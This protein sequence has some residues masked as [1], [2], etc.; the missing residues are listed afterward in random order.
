MPRG[1]RVR[2]A[3]WPP[4]RRVR[5]RARPP[6]FDPPRRRSYNAKMLRAVPRFLAASLLVHGFSLGA[7]VAAAEPVP[8]LVPEFIVEPQVE[9]REAGAMSAVWLRESI[10]RTAPRLRIVPD[11]AWLPAHAGSSVRM[12]DPLS[13]AAALALH[14]VT[15]AG[16]LAQGY[17]TRRDGRYAVEVRFLSLPSGEVRHAGTVQVESIRNVR[18][19]IRRAAALVIEPLVASL[20]RAPRPEIAR[21]A[22]DLAGPAA[23]TA[24][25][26]VRPEPLADLEISSLPAPARVRPP[27]VPEPQAPDAENVSPTAPGL[28]APPEEEDA[29]LTQDRIRAVLA[30]RFRDMVYVPPGPFIMGTDSRKG[31]YEVDAN[32]WRR[33]PRGTRAA[34][35]ELESPAHEVR[36]DGFLIDRNEVTNLQFRTYRPSHTFSAGRDHFPVSNVS[37]PDAL[38]YAQSVGKR[39]PTEAEWEKAARGVEARRWPWGDEFDPRRVAMGDRPMPVGIYPRG[40]SP[41]GVRN[42]AGNVQEWTA[43]TFRPYPGNRR[44]NAAYGEGY[45]V[46]RGS[47]AGGNGFL[48]RTTARFRAEPGRR[49]V[50]PDGGGYRYIGFR[51]ARDLPLPGTLRRWIEAGG[52][53]L[54]AR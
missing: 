51:C 12:T 23:P 36:L 30:K 27:Q 13:A 44:P 26:V 16:L 7:P 39:L 50:R 38:G 34:M 18:D 52:G 40:A 3:R 5:P 54:A 41:Y 32:P 45:R 21:T 11:P 25:R 22:P 29:L 6:P 2:R 43:S 1:C 35:L 49:G 24:P 53:R 28:G 42:M 46:V 4:R 9:I 20:P 17:L 15:G 37:W 48:A 8:V 31:V 33:L 10:R 47:H 14:E 19:G